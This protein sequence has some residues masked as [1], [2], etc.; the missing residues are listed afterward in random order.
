MGWMILVLMVYHLTLREE[1][2]RELGKSHILREILA[3]EKCELVF[4][5]ETARC[6]GDILKLGYVQLGLIWP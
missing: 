5:F 2:V 1:S 4:V 3:G 6:A